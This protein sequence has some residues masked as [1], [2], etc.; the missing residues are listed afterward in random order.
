MVGSSVQRTFLF[1]VFKPLHPNALYPNKSES[2][3]PLCSHKAE[4][5]G[6]VQWDYWSPPHVALNTSTCSF[7]SWNCSDISFHHVASSDEAELYLLSFIKLNF[8][9][10]FSLSLSLFINWVSL[11]ADQKTNRCADVV[12][13]GSC[14]T[15]FE[16]LHVVTRDFPKDGDAGR[17]ALQPTQ[18]VLWS[19]QRCLLLSPDCLVPLWTLH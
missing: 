14:I 13:T 4:A 16:I 11:H 9:Q 17:S 6:V 19:P 7:K 12:Q 15:T 10:I 18:A 8:E 1:F 5:P 2:W 3:F